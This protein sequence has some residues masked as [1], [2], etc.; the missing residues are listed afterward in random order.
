M[1][2]EANNIPIQTAQTIIT[3]A[4]VDAGIV[5]IDEAPEQ[6]VL[7]RAFLQFNWLLAQWQRK[8]YLVYRLVDYLVTS[9]G[10]QTYAVGLGQPFNINPR[11]DRIES[12]FLRILN[13]Q[14][15][16]NMPVDIPM[17]IIPSKEDYNRIPIKN[18][19]TI[20]WRIFYDPV[21]PV[22]VL[23]PWPVPQATIYALNVT[24]K[25]TLGR[26][27]RLTDPIKLPPEYEPA[28]NWCLAR[29]LRASYQMPADPEINQFARDGLN[30]IR[31]GATAVP[32]L[33]MPGALRRRGRGYDYHG[34]DDV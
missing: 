28:I 17:D 3:N 2:N 15:P 12:A 24:F 21:W 31:L 27:A 18:L 22:G 34:S 8:R 7:N 25:E 11:P 4:L 23:Y 16:G 33:Q 32:T 13:A 5:G 29:R 14:S 9:T 20:A 19:G 10:A 1:P 6:P 26:V 30:V